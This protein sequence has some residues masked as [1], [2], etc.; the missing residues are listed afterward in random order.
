[1][2]T[3]WEDY[4]SVLS[5]IEGKNIISGRYEGL[6]S[7]FRNK[8]DAGVAIKPPE[9]EAIARKNR[10]LKTLDMKQYRK[11]YYRDVT[12]PMAT[13][14]PCHWTQEMDAMLLSGQKSTAQL[15]NEWNKT[16]AAVKQRRYK[17]K[18][19]PQSL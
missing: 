17:L 6:R 5:E 7:I 19:A 4:E 15:A 10:K 12:K 11:D 2:T 1:M 18:N 14:S 13:R 16:V 9:V 3:S 8:T